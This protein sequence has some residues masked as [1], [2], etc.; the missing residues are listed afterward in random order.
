MSLEMPPQMLLQDNLLHAD[1]HPGNILLRFKEEGETWMA[2]LKRLVGA[3][4]EPTPHLVLLG[5]CST[6]RPLRQHL[7]PR[8]LFGWGDGRVVAFVS[9]CRRRGHDRRAVQAGP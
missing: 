9:V 6:T 5:T 2:R 3:R 1:L 7:H 4:L 8:L